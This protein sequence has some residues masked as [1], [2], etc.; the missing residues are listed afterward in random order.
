MNI[1]ITKLSI[2]VIL[3]HFIVMASGTIRSRDH[4]HLIYKAWCVCSWWFRTSHYFIV[5]PCICRWIEKFKRGPQFT[6]YYSI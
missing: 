1:K 4:T 5:I 3:S 6:Y 2:A